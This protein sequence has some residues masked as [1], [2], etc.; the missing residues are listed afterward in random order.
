M[1]HHRTG[2]RP[3][4]LHLTLRKS[5][6]EI[7]AAVKDWSDDESR[8]LL[9]RAEAGKGLD[10]FRYDNSSDIS[11]DN[12]QESTE[13]GFIDRMEAIGWEKQ[14]CLSGMVLGFKNVLALEGDD[15]S[16]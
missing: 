13:A 6:S 14:G 7:V 5:S 16:T 2:K 3:N 9:F 11:G 15:T 10:C 8:V 1:P 12:E 4:N